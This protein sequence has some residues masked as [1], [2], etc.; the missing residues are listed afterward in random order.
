MWALWWA[1]KALLVLRQ[2]LFF[3]KRLFYPD[4]EME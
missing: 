4:K 1:R 2:S 3:T